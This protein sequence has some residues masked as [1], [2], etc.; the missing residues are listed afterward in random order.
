[1]ASRKTPAKSNNKSVQPAPTWGGQSVFPTEIISRDWDVPE[2]NEKLKN[3]IWR[4]RALDPVGLYRSNAAGTW[5]SKDDILQ[6]SGDAGL[7]LHKMFG[8]GFTSYASHV[9]KADMSKYVVN[10]RIQAWAMVYEDRGYAAVHNHPNCHASAVYYV[11]NTVPPKEIT[12]ATGVKL[13]SGDI[14]FLD[15][16]SN[17]TMQVTGLRMNPSCII[18]YKTGRMLVF[19]SSLPHYVHPVNGPGERIAIAANANY[20]LKEKS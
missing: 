8:E 10:V 15:T 5:H 7:E 13:R 2:L 3:E 9:Y 12:M 11:D 16:R 4:N 20:T 17:S 14:E 18:G 6:A 1:M 19:P